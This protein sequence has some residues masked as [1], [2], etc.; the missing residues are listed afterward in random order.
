MKNN[1]SLFLISILLIINLNYS[2]GENIKNNDNKYIVMDFYSKFSYENNKNNY[3]LNNF[4]H[5]F[6]YS[7]I[8]LGNKE[9]ILEMRLDLNNYITYIIN[10]DLVNRNIF[11][12]FNEANSKTFFNTTIF[13][14]SYTNDIYKSFLSKDTLTIN[15]NK[16]NN[17]NFAYADAINYYEQIPPGSIGFNYYKDYVIQKENLNFMEQLRDNDII[18]GFSLTFIFI[19]NFKGQLYL[20]PD[21]DK[22]FPDEY[23]FYDK[24]IIK[25]TGGVSYIYNRWGLTFNNIKVG[26]KILN[27]SKTANFNLKEN[28]ILATDEY[29][30]EIYSNYFSQLIIKEQCI[31]EE[32]SYSHNFYTI[33]CKKELNLTNFP[34]LDFTLNDVNMEPFHL[35]LD[36]NNLFE[37]FGEYQYFKI[38]LVSRFD[39]SISLM[40][41][42]SFGK[43]F[44]KEFLM[45]FNKDAKTITFYTKE[46]NR[47]EIMKIKNNNKNLALLI[48]ILILIILVFIIFYLLRK[49]IKQQIEIKNRKRK[50]ILV[51][52]MAYYPED[53][54]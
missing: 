41:E 19:S 22:I 50:N 45:T 15:N 7:K 6:I 40:V 14:D 4:T 12:P 3:F 32:Y 48:L 21:I 1:Y 17:F 51:S 5:N 24:K 35:I 2:S 26:N 36:Y 42:W 38:I 27:Y 46:K 52:E 13:F 33:K 11:V 30:Q 34:V 25:I 9:Q 39:P 47:N 23:S 8:K 20:G 10:K 44:F 37:T 29:S 18:S 31:K 49:C 28:Y 53:K 54:D 16:I 43:V